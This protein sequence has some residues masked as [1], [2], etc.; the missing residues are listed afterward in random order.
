MK[1][2]KVKIGARYQTMLSIYEVRDWGKDLGRKVWV[3]NWGA[4]NQWQ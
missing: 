1:V 4:K 2:R 3:W